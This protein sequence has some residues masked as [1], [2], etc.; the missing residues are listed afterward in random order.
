[1]LLKVSCMI[2]NIFITYIIINTFVFW[3]KFLLYSYFL[4]SDGSTILKFDWEERLYILIKRTVFSRNIYFVYVAQMACKVLIDSCLLKRWQLETL[5]IALDGKP[6]RL[7]SCYRQ[8]IFTIDYISSMNYHVICAFWGLQYLFHHFCG[9]IQSFHLINVDQNV[10]YKIQT[11]TQIIPYAERQTE[12]E[13][14]CVSEN[15]VLFYDPDCERIIVVH[16]TQ[17][18]RRRSRQFR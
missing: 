5:Y 12:R 10:A 4:K 6:R 14:D 7:A 11:A 8:S 18:N 9:V 2:H 3:K 15:C 16:L 17:G 13:S 1:M